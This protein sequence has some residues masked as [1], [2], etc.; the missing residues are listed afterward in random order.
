[1]VGVGRDNDPSTAIGTE[2]YVVIGQAPRQLDRNIALVGRVALG[3]ELLAA[4]PRG[5]GEL[6]FYDQP[7]QRVP[8]QTIRLASDVPAAERKSYEVLR[9]DTPTFEKLIELRRNR[10]DAWYK[11]AAGRIDVCNVP[12]PVREHTDK[13]DKTDKKK[14]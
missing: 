5:N 11:L 12:L 2:L 8:I 7:E 1:M 9:T 6:G 10:K 13:L 4:L 14:S 3:M